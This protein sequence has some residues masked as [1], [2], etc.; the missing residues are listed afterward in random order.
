METV[1]KPISEQSFSSISWQEEIKKK[2]FRNAMNREW[3]EVIE[4]Y[5][6]HP[7][8]HK[9]KITRSGD[10]ALHI[11]ISD[12]QVT[13][14]EQ[15][16]EKILGK[17]ENACDV[18]ETGNELKNTPLHLAAS[19]GNVKMCRLIA[20]FNSTLIGERN[21]DGET[22]F[23]QAFLFGRRDVFLCLHNICG[24]ENGYLYCK[25]KNGETI[26]H[27]AISGEY[28]Y[29][30][31][32]IIQFYPDLINAVTEDGATPLHLLACIP[33]A[34]RSGSYIR[35]FRR[36]IY[37]CI[38]V[39][40]P[41]DIDP[42]HDLSQGS[43]H[44]TKATYPENYQTC[45][46]FAGLVSKIFRV[47]KI[48]RSKNENK[49]I[50]DEE[51]PKGK[52]PDLQR[53]QSSTKYGN[54]EK[55]HVNDPRGQ[56][57]DTHHG[58]SHLP[59]NYVT[60]FN[61]IKLISKS[62]LV[63]L[64]L[65]SH[66]IVKL[67]EKK[68]EHI[69]SVKIMDELLKRA[70]T[71]KYE[72]TGES[73]QRFMS[74]KR[75]VEIP[76][77]VPVAEIPADISKPGD[78]QTPQTSDGVDR[79]KGTN[80]TDIDG[81]SALHLAAKL[82]DHRPWLIPGSALQMQWEIKWYEF[83]K[84]SMPLHFFA[85]YNGQRQT[86]RDI[87]SESHKGFR[88]GYELFQ[89]RSHHLRLHHFL[90]RRRR[91]RLVA[92][93]V[94]VGGGAEEIKKKLFKNAMNR[95]WNEVIETYAQHPWAHEAKITRSG[96]TALH[97]AISC[98]KETIV[99]QLMQEISEKNQNACVVLE[100]GNELGN[101]PL[102]LAASLGNVTMCRLIAGHNPTL[103]GEHNKDGETPFF[104]A[105]LNGKREA[106]S[107]LHDICGTDKGYSYCKKKNGETILHSAISGEYFQLAFTII[108]FYPDLINAVTEDGAIYF[109][110]WHVSLLHSEVEVI[111]EGFADLFTAVS[112]YVD[113]REDIDPKHESSQGLQYDTKAMYPENYQTCIGFAGLVSKIFRVPSKKFFYFILQIGRSKNE[114]KG[115][116]DEENPKGKQPDLQRQQSST[117]YGN[118]EKS[119]VNDPRGQQPDTHHGRSHLP[120]N[121]VTCFNVIK[122]ISKSMLVILGLRSHDI[123]KLR[124]KKE[125]H[126][127]SVK[128]MDALLKRASTNEY[129]N[130][131]ESPQRFMSHKRDV[132]IPSS[133]PLAGDISKP[134]DDQT[135][136]TSDGVDRKKGTNGNGIK[137]KMQGIE[138]GETAL[139]VA[140]KNGVVEMVEKIIKFFP[141]AINDM[142]TSKKKNIVLLA[143]ENRQPHVYRFLLEK[144]TIKE[145][146][147]R[148]VDIDGNSALHLA[149]KLGDHRPWLI[150]GSAL[151]MQWEIKCSSRN[152]C[153]W[154]PLH[155][156]MDR[157][158]RQGTYSVKVTKVSSRVE[159]NG[160]SAPPSHGPLWQLS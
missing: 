131:G 116:T 89:S 136:Q 59:P 26:L 118:N 11:A 94:E 62:M 3:N 130:N 83:V 100:T 142:N 122:L 10:T 64:G 129:E 92:G 74:H 112:I 107:C 38:F 14:V 24:P 20:G 15:L 7:W 29:L 72:N 104:Q 121:Y 144:I 135:P 151:Q 41:E 147:F 117:K 12:G 152:P 18:L 102:H 87:F 71:N 65:G 103:I 31:F 58:R 23:F 139:L 79:K 17:K 35:G 111:L 159:T 53:Q 158:R 123:V 48:G 50:T 47:P 128:I 106:F 124:E 33:S 82:G 145:D 56:Q 97:I 149:A 153:H 60:C 57:P 132:E 157:D 32:T 61:V 9:A 120:P 93:P 143:V 156:T 141:E 85:P 154:T 78:D 63:I 5:A 66:D 13:I 22:P 146:I 51:N 46:G 37:C 148:K 137:K 110:F 36:L 45:I 34:F 49:G 68:E 80:G 25:K 8:A 127:W 150:P 96:D 138:K 67:R 134:G 91:S 6:Q 55:S 105:V 90:L 98:G 109:I 43:Q 69:W 40:E 2:L 76:S 70:S 86:A 81:N 84:E 115:I 27:S 28:F 160:S 99:E 113:E 126:I 39:H 140:A 95:E 108:Q 77:S 4:T 155:P 30:A 125:K 88:S 1:Q 114:N 133:V 101:T 44:D 16:M 73:P 54:N 21:K 52:Q 119:H 42:M 75:D 19:L